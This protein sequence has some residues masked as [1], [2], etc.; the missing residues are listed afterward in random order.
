M[1]KYPCFGKYNFFKNIKFSKFSQNSSFYFG[2]PK[3][4]LV[5]FLDP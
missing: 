4:K 1:E 2:E 5:G 3:I